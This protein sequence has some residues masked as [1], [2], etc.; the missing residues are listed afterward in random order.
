MKMLF[1]NSLPHVVA[2]VLFLLVSYIYFFPLLQGK[3]LPQ[4]DIK[5][6]RG[7]AQEVFDHREKYGEE[8]LWTNTMFGG[9]PAYL[10]STLY[11][12]N[13]LKGINAAVHFA[14]R[15][16]SVFFI[17][18]LGFYI[19]LLS[20]G[21]NPW[22]SI[23]GAMAYGFSS[24]FF[25]ITE[26]GHN[27]KLHA[28]SYVPPM[29]GGIILALRGKY[30]GGLA[31]FALFLGLNLDAGHIQIT[32]YAGF[33]IIAIG[34]AY[35]INAA[36]E[37]KYISFSKSVAVLMLAGVLAIGSS[38]TRL[39]FTYDYGKDSIRGPSELSS[40][41][42][43]RTSGLDKDYA[44]SWSYGKLETLNLLIP[45]LM[46]GASVGSL[47][48]DSHTF[49]FLTDAGVPQGQAR[50]IIRNL[51]LYW[52]T[53]PIT[54]GPVYIGAIV[55]FLFVLGAFLVRGSL[56]WALLAVTA[57]SILLAWGH[58]FMP[59]TNWFLEYFPMYNKFRTVSMILYIAEITM[60]LLG[61]LALKEIMDGR[62]ERKQLML[63]FKWALGITGGICLFFGLFG[64]SLLS[65]EGDIDKR[66][67]SGGYPA[68]MFQALRLDRA[69]LMRADAFRSLAFIAL[70]AL[71]LWAFIVKKLKSGHFLIVIGIL[72]VTDLWVINR[73]YLNNDHFRSRE[74]VQNPFT[75]TPADL[76]ILADSTMYYR[77]YNL[78]L[79]PFQDAS[80]SFFHK[81]IGG[82][83]GAKL[84][85]YQ[86]VIDHH[87]ANPRGMGVLNMLNTRYIIEPSEQ[88]PVP[89]F[90]PAAL[91]NAWFVDSV[92]VV[93]NADQEIE[94]IGLIDPART[95][96]VD[97][98]FAS[99]IE[100]YT[101]APDTSDF[102]E[103]TLY[104]ANR[105]DYRYR[106]SSP[107]L[108]VF[109]DIYYPKGWNAYVNG[110]PAEHFRVNYILRAM[111]LPEGENEISFVF[112]PKMYRTGY[113][114]DLASSLL[115]I[116]LTLAWVATNLYAAR[117]SDLS[118]K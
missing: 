92:R 43:N 24:Y 35:L 111:V 21:V 83:H 6:F 27:A 65:F 58:Y 49:Q 81:S 109:S 28:I 12:G 10:I 79:S 23:V 89:R 85:R 80:T 73:R 59:L 16:A 62:V 51:P 113:F 104:R 44:T 88:G 17:I 53:Q 52:G 40:R 11:P 55:V 45:N 76:Q 14:K 33:I 97:K 20:F 86:E 54:S 39:Y 19:L 15:P 29:L 37:R 56:K 67:I 8:P 7:S 26:A 57:L 103:L 42:Y 9:M 74:R 47:N 98:R 118:E 110:S 117:K 3:D 108:A 114:I 63:G 60:P 22:L 77:V 32:Y 106:L 13:L 34:I 107:R 4:H 75:A 93:E 50:S 41:E 48:T 68:E 18:F 87:L 1:K 101:S 30:L 69:D 66:Y 25:I 95:A 61:I 94:A 90:N 38:F 82:Y 46:G 116:I 115:I 71:A 5:Q 78:S 96:I 105:L 64:S 91:G 70:G 100:G 2:V 102:I 72:I 36:I 112:K 84:R 31:I 99:F